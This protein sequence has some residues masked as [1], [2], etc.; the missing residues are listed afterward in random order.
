L[1][2][3]VDANVIVYSAVPGEYRDGCLEVLEA[4]ARG[5]AEGRTST[6]VLEEVWHIELSRRAGDLTGLTEHAYVLMTPLLAVTDEA[7]QLA[8]SLE[9]SELGANDRLHVGTCLVNGI[10]RVVSADRELDAVK[11]ITRVDPRDHRAR[12][13]LLAYGG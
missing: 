1:T 3:F 4:V 2:F 5:E 13:R 7:L 10:D 6:A 12:R 9:V 11:A 8:L